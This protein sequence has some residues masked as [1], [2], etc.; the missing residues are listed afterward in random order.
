MKSILLSALVVMALILGAW[1]ATTLLEAVEP[2]GTKLKATLAVPSAL[3]SGRTVKLQFTL[4]NNSDE[5]LYVLQWYT[6]LEGLGG[7]IFRVER[8]G[9]LVPYQGIL[10]LRGDPS[11]DAYI[12]LGAGGSVSAEVDLA[13]AY[14]FSKPGEYTIE[15]LSPSISDVART[16]AEMA[17]TV[18]DLSPVQIPSNRVTIQIGGPSG[19]AV[20]PPETELKATIAVPATLPSGQH[21]KLLFTLTNNSDQKL[22][23]LQWYT[24]LEGLGGEIFRVER[25][26]EPI[27][28]QGILAMR[29]DPSPDAYIVLG[30]Q[31]SVSAEVDL[32]TAYDFSKAGEYSIEFLS[33]SISHVA[34]TEAE[35]AKTVDDLGPVQIPSNTV[36]TTIVSQ[37][38]P[39]VGKGY[40]LYS[41]P[42]QEDWHFAL[43]VGTNRL[44]TYD[45]VISSDAV[46]QGVEALK[47]ELAGLPQGEIVFWTAW[48]VS[49]MAIPPDQIVDLVRAYCQE[50]GL[51]LYVVQATGAGAT[52][53][54]LVPLESIEIC[55]LESF[56][57]QIH[58]LV[59]G[60]LPDDCTVINRISES[61]VPCVEDDTFWV[62]V[63][64]IRRAGEACTSSPIPFEGTIPLDVYGLPAGVYTV[65][66][67]GIR[68]TFT[69]D[70]DN[71]PP[72]TSG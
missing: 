56:P 13:T 67:N 62:E 71:M 49:G 9:E 32:A 41:W 59:K 18:D 61:V 37:P 12:L 39:H 28:Y 34:R 23:V 26:G 35:M 68:E 11:P 14:D 29:G 40:E 50:I 19:E 48:H 1:A 16:E 2:P 21:V 5:R 4:T 22:Y 45:E 44:K 36:T 60:K 43:L 72:S 52:P 58:V 6:P 15:F 31:E 63:T 55:T 53:P 42:G 24:P 27:P 25:D 69:L 8:D 66:V 47:N 54:E 3:P 51:E 46:V 38:L 65:D 64:T 10:A 33:P 7:E 57:V 70:V 17:K 20:E 30:A